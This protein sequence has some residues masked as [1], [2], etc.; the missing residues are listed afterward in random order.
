[1]FGFFWS[2]LAMAVSNLAWWSVGLFLIF[3][4][5]RFLVI[6][7]VAQGILGD[8]RVWKLLWALPIREVLAPLIWLLT[9][10]GNTIV[11]RGQR[12]RLEKG[13]LRKA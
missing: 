13:Q 3:Y 10:G 4:L 11:W 6:K 2:V 1:T 5:F 8:T 9:L 12:F 7:V